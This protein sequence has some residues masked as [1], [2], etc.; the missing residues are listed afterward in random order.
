MGP[1]GDYVLL[2][3]PLASK[4]DDSSFNRRSSVTR[5]PAI[6]LGQNE[7]PKRPSVRREPSPITP[8]KSPQTGSVLDFDPLYNSSSTPSRQQTVSQS[9]VKV[10][11]T[12]DEDSLLKDW[13]IGGLTGFSN[14]PKQT[15]NQ[16]G[17]SYS[18][19]TPPPRQPINPNTPKYY[20]PQPYMSNTQSTLG[21]QYSPSN[22]KIPPSVPP[23][24]KRQANTVGGQGFKELF[25][26]QSTSDTRNQS[27]PFADLISL[28]Q[29]GS[30]KTSSSQS[31]SWETFN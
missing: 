29:S 16:S 18:Q 21:L 15:L 12:D 17:L 30:Q 23:R 1:A 24:P 25:K 4:M 3:E 5:T 13:N 26:A 14:T 31:A 9:S 6:K 8:E 19:P 10:E 28:D 11:Q 22:T 2:R 20:T 27:D 7:T